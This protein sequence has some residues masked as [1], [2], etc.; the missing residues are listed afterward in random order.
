MKFLN[1]LKSDRQ[2]LINSLQENIDSL[3]KLAYEQQA[4][5]ERLKAEAD[6]ADGY[7]EALVEKAKSEA[8][9]EFAE[10][11]KAIAIE[12][13]SVPIVF[14]DI[15]NLLKEMVGDDNA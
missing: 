15:D 14:S 9:K 13:G 4:E 10:R 7:A 5:I 8:I 12:K 2:D 3:E 6:C 11:L 1:K